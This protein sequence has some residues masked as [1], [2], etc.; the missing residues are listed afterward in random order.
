MSAWNRWWARLGAVLGTVV[1]S[2]FVPV[3]AWASTATGELVT[4]EARRRSRG[5]FGFL[6]LFCCLVGVGV[7]VLLVFVLM[8]MTR[9]R[10]G[11]PPR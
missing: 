6:G 8:R 2:V 5:A 10:R 4:E 3:A 1:L 7:I 9:N 11:G